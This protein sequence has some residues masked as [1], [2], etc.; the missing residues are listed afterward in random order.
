MNGPAYSDIVERRMRNAGLHAWPLYVHTR[1]NGL[2]CAD[3]GQAVANTFLEPT[4][5]EDGRWP[6]WTGA[7]PPT[8]VGGAVPVDD[9]YRVM[10]LSDPDPIHPH[11]LN[12]SKFIKGIEKK[13]N[14]T[15][16]PAIHHPPHVPTLAP[17]K[18]TLL[19]SFDK[20]ATTFLSTKVKNMGIIEASGTEQPHPPGSRMDLQIGRGLSSPAPAAQATGP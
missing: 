12:N 4:E 3:S 10:N 15:W 1:C 13:D 11:A 19:L 6:D 5:M 7:P 17:C 18:S 9:E 20:H 14:G 8:G 16:P 2:L